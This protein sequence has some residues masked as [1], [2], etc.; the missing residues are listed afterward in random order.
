MSGGPQALLSRKDRWNVITTSTARLTEDLD[1]VLGSLG[2]SSSVDTGVGNGNVD[3]RLPVSSVVLAH[4]PVDR[5]SAL[6]SEG[7]ALRCSPVICTMWTY[8]GDGLE[9]L[10]VVAHVVLGRIADYGMQRC[11]VVHA[12][13]ARRARTKAESNIS[14][15]HVTHP[16][17]A[18]ASC[19]SS[20]YTSSQ[21]YLQPIHQHERSK[22]NKSLVGG[23]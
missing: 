14:L 2:K 3:E 19:P 10:L 13:W 4:C 16:L 7:G 11:K 5:L 21:C 23:S 17:N 1:E 12:P 15:D 9:E 22:S 20:P 8:L 18:L 6:L